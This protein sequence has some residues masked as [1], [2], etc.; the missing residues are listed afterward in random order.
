MSDNVEQYDFQKLAGVPIEEGY[1]NNQK[2]QYQSIDDLAVFQGDMVLS[3]ADR[4][5]KEPPVAPPEGVERGIVQTIHP[6][7][8]NATVPFVINNNLP[9]QRRVTDA[10]Q[11]WEQNT[12]LRFVNR[13]SESDY[14]EF[15]AST[16]CWSYVGMQGGKQQIGLA[17]GCSTGNTIHEIGHAIGLWHE[18]SREDRDQWIRVNYQNIMGNREHNFDQHIVDGQDTFFY[19]YGSIMHYSARAFSKNNQDTIT[20]LSQGAEIG[21][22][23]GLSSG[24]VLATNFMYPGKYFYIQ[25]PLNGYV[26]DIEGNSTDKGTRIISYPKKEQKADNQLWTFTT[27]GFIQSKLN[28]FVLDIKGANPEAGTQIISW[29][30]K[31]TGISNQL[32]KMTW[33]GFIVSELNDFVLDIKGCSTKPV[34]PII[35]YPR[36]ESGTENQQWKIVPVG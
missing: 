34:T 23:S 32:W 19:D 14:I 18:Q 20:V 33:D 12:M 22:R 24:D 29:P 1:Y 13:T 6:T 27:D 5:P 2:I 36:K 10:I 28:D 9:N 26:L 8:P 25:S 4:I 35:S 11:H 7:W 16:G 15:V 31:T 30:K 17:D 3:K 21:Q